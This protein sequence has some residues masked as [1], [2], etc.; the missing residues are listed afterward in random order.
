MGFR[1]PFR[2]HVDEKTGW[3]LMGDYGP[4]AGSTNPDARPAGLRRVQRGQGA[5]LLRLAL[6]RP[7]ERPVPRHHLRRVT[8]NNGNTGQRDKG[9]YN[10]AAPVNDSP[11]NTGLTNL[12]PAIPATMWMGYSELDTRF[13]DLGGGGAP[14]GGTRYYYDEDSTSET[15]FP[16]F[17]DGHWFIG[18]WNNDWVKTTSLNQEG[19]ATGVECF[20]V[21]TGYISPMDIEFGPNGSMYVVE[22][23][24]GFNENNPDSG[25][26]R[27]DYIQGERQPIANASAD[28]DAVPVGATVNFSSAGSNDPDGTDITYLW[29]FKD[30]TPTSTAANPSHTFTAAGTY[31]VTLTVTDA[32]GD[33]CRGHDPRRRRQPAARRD[34][35]H[36]GERQGR[37]LRRQ[38]RVRGDRHRSGRRPRRHPAG[39]QRGRPG[40][41]GHPHRG[42]ARARHARPRARLGDRLLR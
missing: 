37:G 1:N 16:P 26:Y 33:S 36:A 23:G 13:P 20:A 14:T 6:L 15:K 40:V 42:E 4:D 12:P 39:D 11:N 17:Y 10:C 31:D 25:V 38:G 34:H 2:I 18:E 30:G 24:Q 27:I 21:C 41:R 29:D 7:P 28:N 19:L 32:S 5:G 35:R 9:L 22:W 8:G 3:V